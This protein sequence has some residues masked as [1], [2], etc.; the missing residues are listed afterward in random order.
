[1]SNFSEV[2]SKEIL[3]LVLKQMK[4]AGTNFMDAWVKG[5]MPRKITGKPYASMNLFHLWAKKA[6]KGY[7]SNTWATFNHIRGLKTDDGEQGMVKKGE[8][9]TYV[10]GSFTTTEKHTLV[11]GKDKGKIVERDKWSMKFYPVFNLD[12]TNIKDKDVEIPNGADVVDSVENYVKNTGADVRI[13]SK[14]WNPFL[15]DSC[16]YSV[17]NDYISMVGKQYFKN[18]QESSATLNYYSVLLH[19]LTHW[20][21]HKDRCNRSFL[22]DTKTKDGKPDPK[23]SYAMEELVAEMGSAIQSCKLGIA[24]K[25]KIES[26]QYLNIWIKRLENNSDL[27]RKMCTYATQAVWFI[28]KQQPKKLKKAS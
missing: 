27:F 21:M 17:T 11:R 10:V 25:P 15:T 18:T 20:T 2:K 8:K 23:A 16:F 1:M 28:E 5:G 7:V 26:A 13:S 9:A 3:E 12:Q 22:E 4:T 6:D 14:N 19:E 24:S